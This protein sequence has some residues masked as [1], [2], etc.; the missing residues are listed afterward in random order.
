MEKQKVIV[1]CGPTASGKT[2][3][4]IELAK[5]INGEI[6]SCDSMQIYK[7]MDIGTAK[8]TL[9]EMQGIKHYMIGIISPN[10]RYS[11]ADY[12]KDAKKAI[13][14]ILNKGKVPIVV[15]GT[16]L[17]IDSLIYEI[18]YQ[19][20]EFDKEYREHLE[21]EVKE[22]GL[23]ELYN[24]AK[25]IDPEAIEKISKNDKKRILRILEIYHA[26]GENKTEQE[27]KSRQKEVEYDYK[28]YALNMDREKLYDRI[29]K[30]VDKMIEEGL[31]Q[32]VEKIYKKY[33]DFPTAMQGLGYKEVVEYL[34]GKL[35][36]EEMIEKIK[37][38][39]RRY[40]KRQLTWFR[41]NKQTIW[42]DVGKNT[43]QNNIEIIL[44]GLK[45]E[46]TNKEANKS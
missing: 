27:R 37:Q 11:V 32:E 7:E 39:T 28:V 23:E 40:A 38:E 12:K 31:I 41:K 21:K 45:V 9:E 25:E 10:E 34:E 43:I 5:K 17:Y 13:R 20:I 33:N 46:R 35:T 6:V 2:A 1:I 15:G 44:E 16:G 3:L 24:V 4:S 42:L 26:T 29:N 8:P 30:R 36:K 19:D 22:K 18:E 14:E